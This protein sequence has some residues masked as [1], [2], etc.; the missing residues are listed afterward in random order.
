MNLAQLTD[1]FA[2]EHGVS[3]AVAKEQIKNVFETVKNAVRAG[4]DVS[5]PDF[6]KFTKTVRA[7]RNG[8]NPA[9][10]EKVAIPEKT[11]AKFKQ[12]TVFFS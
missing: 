2:E 9:T 11:I 7:A 4:N 3:K 12:S 8:H 5:I 1:Q 10:G 6:G